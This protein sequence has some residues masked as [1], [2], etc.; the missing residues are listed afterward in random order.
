MSDDLTPQDKQR[1]EEGIE[2]KLMVKRKVEV[3]TAGCPDCEVTIY[4]PN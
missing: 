3:F 2:V 1:I 4:N